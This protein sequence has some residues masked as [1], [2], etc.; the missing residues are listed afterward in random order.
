MEKINWGIMGTGSIAGAFARGLKSLPDAE[1][2]AVGSR[3]QVTADRFGK[4]YQVPHCY[5]SYEALVQD[6]DVDVIYIATPHPFHKDNSRLALEAGKAVLCE[7][8]FTLNAAEAETVINTARQKQLFLMEAMWMRFIPAMVKVRELLTEGAIGEIQ[9]IK[10]DFGFRATFDP[11]NRLF[12]P[13]LGGGALL[14]VGIYP[15]SLASMV[16]GK[17][18]EATGMAQLGPTGVDEQTAILLKYPQGQLALLS[19]AIRTDTLTEAVLFGTEGYIKIHNPLYRPNKLTVVCKRHTDIQPSRLPSIIKRIGYAL[20]LDKVWQ[21]IKSQP[22]RDIKLPVQGN[23]YNYE[24]AEVMRCLRAGALES[25]IMPLDET[26]TLMQTLDQ[27]RAQW[28]LVYP[29]EV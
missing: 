12:S 23:G 22:G 13:E 6:Q 7:K 8:P 4:L 24:A 26:L 27:L 11:H 1:L 28:G 21:Q 5:A 15:L 10:A 20:R 9:M 25:A 14:D 17:P 29:S 3:K 18:I 16:L 19:A 2:I